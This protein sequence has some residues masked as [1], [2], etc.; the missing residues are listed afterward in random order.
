[1]YEWVCVRDRKYCC[2]CNSISMWSCVAA[3]SFDCR[4]R[5]MRRLIRRKRMQFVKTRILHLFYF[6][7]RSAVWR[8][9]AGRWSFWKNCILKAE[10]CNQSRPLER[11]DVREILVAYLR[12]FVPQ[13]REPGQN[14]VLLLIFNI[15]K[16]VSTV[17]TQQVGGCAYVW[18]CFNIT[19]RMV[20]GFDC[21]ETA[22]GRCASPQ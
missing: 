20:A 8:Q 7:K 1:M 2:A 16:H 19:I 10:G 6:T 11:S 22:V 5:K 13:K 14:N 17:W 21:M 9:H 3:E 15:I 18:V 4:F 12:V